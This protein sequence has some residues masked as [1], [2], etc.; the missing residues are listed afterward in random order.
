METYN[1]T[2]DVKSTQGNASCPTCIGDT[3]NALPKTKAHVTESSSDIGVSTHYVPKLSRKTDIHWYALRCTYGSERKTYEYL[4][5]HGVE[6]FYP[7]IQSVKKEKGKIITIESSRI[8]NI[9]FAHATEKD[10]KTYVYDNI[11]LPHLRFYYQHQ[12]V[13]NARTKTPL[14]VPDRQMQSLMI[15]CKAATND[16]ITTPEMVQRFKTGQK[17]RI[18]DGEFKGVEGVVARYHSQ[19]RVGMVIDGLMTACTAYVPSG[20]VENV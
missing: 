7:T 12:H 16:V 11:N 4:I 8:P 1:A 2:S 9:L 19:Q 10:I 18:I 20:F 14:I 13:G 5:A 3:T 17:V 6:A 15:I